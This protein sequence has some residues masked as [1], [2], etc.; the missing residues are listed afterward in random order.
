MAE[1]A[2]FKKSVLTGRIHIHQKAETK[3]RARECLLVRARSGLFNQFLRTIQL[4]ERA[5]GE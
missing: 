5:K 4:A 1:T 3:R 2:G